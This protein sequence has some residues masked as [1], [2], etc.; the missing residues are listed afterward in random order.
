MDITN[1]PGSKREGSDQREVRNAGM[2]PEGTEPQLRA[3]RGKGKCLNLLLKRAC[4][5]PEE[6]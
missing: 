2:N 3:G 1:F 6:A 5:V 4:E